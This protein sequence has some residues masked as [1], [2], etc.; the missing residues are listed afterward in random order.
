M[1]DKCAAGTG[2]FLEVMAR[3]LGT[4]VQD[5]D[6]LAGHAEPVSITSMC[7][8]FAESEVISL[9]AK[10]ATREAIARGVLES[11]ADRAI[12]L[13]GRNSSFRL[14][15][16]HRRAVA[17][18]RPCQHYRAAPWHAR[19]HLPKLPDSRSPRRR[20]HR[21]ELR[22]GTNA[23]YRQHDS[24]FGKDARKRDCRSADDSRMQARKSSAR[25]ACLRQRS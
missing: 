1:N 20:R 25:T 12:G 7:A 8:V 19:V 24:G 13:L 2:R 3:I 14:Y 21:L 15:C 16:L 6:S 18:P 23:A 11:I 17:Q 5:L 10:G 4:E 9:M 22:R